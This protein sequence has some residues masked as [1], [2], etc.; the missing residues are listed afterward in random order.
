VA[1]NLWALYCQTGLTAYDAIAG[2]LWITLSRF[3]IFRS[4][5][6]I[7]ELLRKQLTGKRFAIKRRR[8]ASCHLLP[9]CAWNPSILR[10]DR[11]LG[12][13]GGQILE[14]IWGGLMC[15]ICWPCTVD[16]LKSQYA[17]KLRLSGLIG[18]ASHPDMQKIRIIG[19]FFKYATLAVWSSAIT[20]YSMYPRL[21][22]WTKPDLKLYRDADKSLARPGRK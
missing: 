16:T 6:S 18:T 19:F 21:N 3:A 5:I 2:R 7:F 22:L 15:T 4:V 20:I 14:C 17:V 13:R 1:Q 11:S 8:E 10:G 12:S 9:A